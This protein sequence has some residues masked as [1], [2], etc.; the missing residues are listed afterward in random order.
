VRDNLSLRYG[1]D[2]PK[3]R[4]A[5]MADT[6]VFQTSDYEYEAP[7]NEQESVAESRLGPVSLSCACARAMSS[8]VHCNV[9]KFSTWASFSHVDLLK[10]GQRHVIVEIDV[11]SMFVTF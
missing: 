1:E 10:L 3:V 9:A 2:H 7:N 11:G 6:Y 5:D 4:E 8:H